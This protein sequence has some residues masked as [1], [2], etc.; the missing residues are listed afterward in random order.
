[1]DWSR[2]VPGSTPEAQVGHPSV[3]TPLTSPPGKEALEQARPLLGPWCRVLPFRHE[4]LAVLRAL[5]EGRTP[6]GLPEGEHYLVLKCVGLGQVRPRGVEALLGRALMASTGE[7]GVAA[8]CA[9]L[10]CTAEL[11]LELAGQGLIQ[12]HCQ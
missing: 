1:M 2:M 3:G 9:E 7:R 12:L 4:P 10:G 8:L 6:T 11:F 5:D